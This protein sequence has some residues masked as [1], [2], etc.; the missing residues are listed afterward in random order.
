MADKSKGGS[1]GKGAGPA[2]SSSK[3]STPKGGAASKGS[4]PA[5]TSGKGGSK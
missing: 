3:G 1:S 4:G 2:P 5:P